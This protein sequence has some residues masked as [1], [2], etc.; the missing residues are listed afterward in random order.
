MMLHCCQQ[1]LPCTCVKVRQY[2][3]G[4]MQAAMTQGIQGQGFPP[5]TRALTSRKPSGCS[6]SR[7]AAPRTPV[8][9]HCKK[10]SRHRL[11]GI[12]HHNTAWEGPVQISCS[13]GAACLPAARCCAHRSCTA[14]LHRGIAPHSDSRGG[15]KA[16]KGDECCCAPLDLLQVLAVAGQQ[17]RRFIEALLREVQRQIVLH[18]IYTYDVLRHKGQCLC[19][20]QCVSHGREQA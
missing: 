19:T 8:W 6:G 7:P 5:Q 12:P 11:G 17:Q 4:I 16:G 13:G 1:L 9:R 3:S 15:H 10:Q 14:C 18:L 2:N 20:S